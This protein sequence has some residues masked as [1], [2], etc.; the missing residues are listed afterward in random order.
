MMKKININEKKIIQSLIVLCSVVFVLLSF[1]GDKGY[2]ELR[3][4]KQKEAK[5]RLEIESLKKNKQVW[6]HK[7]H[8]I[9]TDQTYFETYVREQLG[10]VRN[11][12]FLVRFSVTED[13]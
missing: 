2:I 6:L 7:I 1:L 13:E 11:Y 9:K 12:E 4:L 3:K 5:I 10:Y 8:S